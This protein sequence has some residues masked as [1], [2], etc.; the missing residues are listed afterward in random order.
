M[1]I[2]VNCAVE[3]QAANNYHCPDRVDPIDPNTSS[4]KRAR[5]RNHTS[6]SSTHALTHSLTGANNPTTQQPNNP[7]TQ[8]PNNDVLVAHCS[9]A[10]KSKKSKVDYQYHNYQPINPAATAS[11]EVQL[12]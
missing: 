8:Q 7:T 10:S 2:G 6:N 11:N 9:C 4:N 12:D 5:D 3:A 1:M